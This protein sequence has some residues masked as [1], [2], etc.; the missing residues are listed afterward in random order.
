MADWFASWGVTRV[1][2]EPTSDYWT[3][4]W[5]VPTCSRPPG[6]SAG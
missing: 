1:V 3:T 4:K 5:C 6:S 2:T